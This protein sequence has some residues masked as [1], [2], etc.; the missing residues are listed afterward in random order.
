MLY[1]SP[2][3]CETSSSKIYVF[4]VNL[5]GCRRPEDFCDADKPGFSKPVI[6]LLAKPDEL[7]A[8]EAVGVDATL[9]GRKTA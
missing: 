5:D 4:L 1:P 2:G 6:L 8:L 9:A 7:S 3:N